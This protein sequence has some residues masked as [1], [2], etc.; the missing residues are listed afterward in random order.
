VRTASRIE[1]GFSFSFLA[2]PNPPLYLRLIG[3]GGFTPEKLN[4]YE[5]GYR[6][7]L[8][9]RG[10][11]SVALFHNRYEDLLSVESRPLAAEATPEPAHLVL[12]LYLRN[13]VG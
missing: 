3:D 11:V 8:S 12:P 6:K 1:D 5:V 2:Q 9:A 10:F 7:Y 13:G 4:A